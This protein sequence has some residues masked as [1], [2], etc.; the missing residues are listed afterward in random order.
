MF[1]KEKICKKCGGKCCKSMPGA[2]YPEDFNLSEDF[3]KFEVALSS[4]EIAID[5][6]EGDARENLEELD[7]TYFLRP[8][9][10][11]KIGVLYDPS[12][13]GECIFLTSKG[14]KLEGDERPLNCKKLEPGK[15]KCTLHDNVSK[16]GAAIAW[17]PYQKY[18]REDNKSLNLT[19]EKHPAG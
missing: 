19:G 5:W 17:I 14:C 9:I 12:W 16:Q 6:W 15:D 8:S 18:L 10:K 11:D 3:S 13:G 7:R 2:Y 4:G 1:V